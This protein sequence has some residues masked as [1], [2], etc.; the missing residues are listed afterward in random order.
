V[1]SM[2]RPVMCN[3]G[4][5]NVDLNPKISTQKSY[6]NTVKSTPTP[7]KALPA[8]R[9]NR[10]NKET[11]QQFPPVQKIGKNKTSKS[12]KSLENTTIHPWK[13][14][15]GGT[16]AT[17]A[18]KTEGRHEHPERKARNL[19]LRAKQHAQ[20]GLSLCFWIEVLLFFSFF[21][22]IFFFY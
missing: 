6:K 12:S 22:S 21:F 5:R 20:E 14:A 17:L 16:K 18:L 2:V 11:N 19:P 15:H 10:K 8:Q 13:Q 7:E 3:N 1:K 9:D 4:E